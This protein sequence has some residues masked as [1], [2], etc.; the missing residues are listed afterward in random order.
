[1]TKQLKEAIH[2]LLSNPSCYQWRN[3]CAKE[4]IYALT[5]SQKRERKVWKAM[6][7]LCGIIVRRGGTCNREYGTRCSKHNCPLLKEI[8]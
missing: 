5:A 4:V 7:I 2:R 6:N 3:D 1:M 8:K